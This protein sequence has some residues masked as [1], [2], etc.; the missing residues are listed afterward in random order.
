M[1]AT[2]RPWKVLWKYDTH[3]VK[4]DRDGRII[5]PVTMDFDDYMHALTCVNTHERAKARLHSLMNTLERLAI[6]KANEPGIGNELKEQLKWGKDLL[7]DME[8]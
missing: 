3:K 5:G 8:G 1:N 6:E 2:P 7:A 4:R